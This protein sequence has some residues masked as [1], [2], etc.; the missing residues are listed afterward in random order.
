MKFSLK[1]TLTQTEKTIVLPFFQKEVDFELIENL[2]D[3]KSK[4]DFSGNFKEV[5]LLYHP[6]QN[7]RIFLLGL[8][9]KKDAHKTSAAY[10]SFAFAHHSKFEGT[11][12]V[13]LNH[14]SVEQAFEACY[15]FQLA[16]YKVGMY[17]REKKKNAPFFLKTYKVN[18]FHESTQTKKEIEKGQATGETQANMMCLVDMPAAEKTPEY[19]GKYAL[20]SAKKYQYKAKVFHKKDLEKLGCHAILG[21]GRGSNNPPVMIQLEYKPKGSKSKRPVLGLVGKGITFDTGGISIKGSSNLHYMKSDM[22]GGAAVLGAIELAAKLKLNTHIVGIIPAAENAVDAASILPGDILDSYSKK[23]IEIIDTD[24]EGR[25][26]LA[27]GLAYVIEQFKPKY[28]VD[29]ATLTGSCVRTLGYA[30]GGMFTHNDE[31][32][33]TISEVGQMTQEKVWRLPLWDDYKDDI[34]S[35]IADVRNFSGKPINGAIS[36]AK[37]LEVFVKEHPNWVHLDIAGVSF[38]NNEHSKMKSAKGYGVRLMYEL[39]ARLK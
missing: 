17:K 11:P 15:G 33:Q 29:L 7:K 4:I 30:A 24:A 6:S 26:V 13:Y 37:F 20:M 39:A 16:T 14:L 27:D 3:I 35:D 38:G 36:A 31:L 9:D 12:T 8:G 5:V 23:T 1:K 28:L 10:R 2:S 22:G 34:E 21:V 18:I 25:L 32:A 19:I